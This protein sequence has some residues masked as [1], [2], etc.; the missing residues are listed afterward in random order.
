MKRRHLLGAATAAAGAALW[1]AWL[2]EAFAD[3]PACNAKSGAGGAAAR[4][5]VVAAAYRA[6]R[7]AK[8]PLLVFVIP[9]ADVEKWSRGQAFGELL[10]HGDD[11]QLAPLSRVEV[12]CA[13]M[14]DL[15]KL[16]PTA[17][18]GEPLMVLVSTDRVPA[19]ARQLDVKLPDYDVYGGDDGRSN[20]APEKRELAIGQRR[21]AAMAG[22]I[23]GALGEADKQAPALAA[24]VRQHLKVKPPPGARWASSSGCGTTIEGDDEGGVFGCGM[25][26]VPELSRRFLYFFAK[27]GF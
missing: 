12:V 14:A 25:G 15:R 18:A 23:R 7:A 19:V 13:T 26:H 22:L 27:R 2:K 24:A 3:A 11:K 17:G 9:D 4:L 16:V 8:R 5:A 6:A 1:P 21:V 20:E 10:N